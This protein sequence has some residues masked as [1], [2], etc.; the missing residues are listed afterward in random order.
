MEIFD[1]YDRDRF[2]TGEVMPRGQ[3]PPIGRYHLVV[4]ICIF[5]Q[6]GQMLIQKRSQQKGF[7][8]GL[9]DV[10]VGGAAQKVIPAGWLPNGSYW[11]NWALILISAKSDQ[12]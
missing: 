10:S 8:A 4:H 7:W 2:P 9:W 3:K 6:E 11:K 5:N 1:L 12:L